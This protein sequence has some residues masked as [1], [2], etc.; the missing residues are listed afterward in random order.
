MVQLTYDLEP[1]GFLNE[2]NATQG[3]CSGLHGPRRG[4]IL[5]RLPLVVTQHHRNRLLKQ[6]FFANQLTKFSPKL[7]LKGKI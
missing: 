6:A 7:H 3:S 4:A 5:L 1:A 2:F